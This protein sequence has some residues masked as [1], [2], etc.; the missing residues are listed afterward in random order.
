[1][2]INIKK[3]NMLWISCVLMTL[4]GIH[5]QTKPSNGTSQTA[6]QMI[7]QLDLGRSA[8]QTH[9]IRIGQG[10]EAVNY[11]VNFEKGDISVFDDQGTDIKTLDDLMPSLATTDVEQLGDGLFKVTR[12]G[13]FLSR[14]VSV[15]DLNKGTLTHAADGSVISVTSEGSANRCPWCVIVVIARIVAMDVCQ[16]GAQDFVAQCGTTCGSAG[17]ATVSS[18][19][20]GSGGSCSC[21]P[22]PAQ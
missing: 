12:G 10:R 9:Q 4:Q 5:A 18:G 14:T 8:G 17:V 6:L 2:N 21:N 15:L 13:S 11:T 1:M 20:C 7:N 22:P 16:Q 19:T 3:F